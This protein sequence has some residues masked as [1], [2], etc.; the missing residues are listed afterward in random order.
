MQKEGIV[1][2]KYAR[3]ALKVNDLATSLH[4]YVDIL[5]LELIESLPESDMAVVRDPEGSLLLLAGPSVVELHGLLEEPHLVYKQGD[6]IEFFQEDLGACLAALTARGL[7]AIEQ[8]Q[9]EAGDRLVII[10]DPSHST[11]RYV[12]LVQHSPEETLA[13]Y[14]RGGEEIEAVL[15]GLTEA[16]LDL[17]RSPDEWSIRQIVHHLAET[18]SLFLMTFESALAQ[19]GCTFIRNPYDQ[20]YWAE[21]LAYKERAI[22][23]SMALIKAMRDHLLQLFQYI[24]D[25]WDRY[26]LLKFASWEGEGDKVTVGGLLEGLN[27]HLAEHCAE[28]RETRRMHSR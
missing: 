3:V 27:R 21:A 8:A 5:G 20:P 25:F 15:T 6:T 16:D 4:F 26:V 10:K 23:P 11:I 7:T 13:T 17:T 1:M 28:I 24:P 19:P 9:T 2:A 18:D 12:Q 14:A 22:E